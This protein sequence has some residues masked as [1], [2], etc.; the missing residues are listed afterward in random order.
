MQMSWF[1]QIFPDWKQPCSGIKAPFPLNSMHLDTKVERACAVL[2]ICHLQNG[3]A[4]CTDIT[5]ASLWILCNALVTLRPTIFDSAY[6]YVQPACLARGCAVSIP[7]S[8]ATPFFLACFFM[9]SQYDR[10][11]D[12]PHPHC[13]CLPYLLKFAMIDQIIPGR[14]GECSFCKESWLLL[15]KRENNKDSFVRNCEFFRIVK[16]FLVWLATSAQVNGCT[17]LIAS[18]KNLLAPCKAGAGNDALVCSTSV[19]R[20]SK[21]RWTIF[22]HILSHTFTFFHTLLYFSR[23]RKLFLKTI[24]YFPW[25]RIPLTGVAMW[26]C[27]NRI[28]MCHRKAEGQGQSANTSP[29]FLWTQARHHIAFV[30]TNETP[31]YSAD[32][33]S[34]SSRSRSITSRFLTNVRKKMFAHVSGLN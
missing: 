31:I 16:C 1:C 10:H 34:Q 23:P 21:T 28:L 6:C 20:P 14:Q 15:M 11:W 26:W 7:C 25:F 17:G 32:Y 9:T 27:A 3:I 5:V 8:A 19:G 18:V 22:F 4:S 29:Y 12:T 2:C 13:W 24:C 30:S 33:I